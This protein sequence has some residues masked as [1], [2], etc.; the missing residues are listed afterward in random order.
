MQPL[1]KPAQLSIVNQNL[2]YY[3]EIAEQYDEILNRNHSNEIIRE[4]VASI[5]SELV[6]AGLVLD[7][8][9]GTGK[10]TEWLA[11]KGYRVIFCEPSIKMR[12]KAVQLSEAMRLN[13]IIFLGD[14]A[15]DFSTWAVKLPFLEKVDAVLA[16][17]AV[18]NNIPDIK[19]LF[20]NLSLVTKTGGH[21]LM[22]VLKADLKIRW[23][24]NRQA[25]FLS[26]FGGTTVTG[27]TAFNGKKQKVQLHT[28]KKI[29]KSAAAYFHFSN[30]WSFKETDFILLHLTRK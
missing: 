6:F 13:D 9:G 22:L 24:F 19:L 17:F 27:Y 12:E 3:N 16:N 2:T 21:L 28:V 11:K 10:D 15:S 5:F 30:S 7:F 25:T 1:S 8:G 29:K 4:K 14:D 26:L 18:I 20:K 23:R